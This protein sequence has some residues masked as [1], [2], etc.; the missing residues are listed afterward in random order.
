MQVASPPERKEE[1]ALS[2]ETELGSRLRALTGDNERWEPL[3]SKVWK[4]SLEV[5]ND[6]F[7]NI[8]CIV[9]MEVCVF[10]LSWQ[11]ISH[12]LPDVQDRTPARK[13]FQS[14]CTCA[15]RCLSSRIL[16]RHNTILHI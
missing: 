3:M 5:V 1:D 15:S 12:L 9:G 13:Y 14:L 10:L 7:K 8:E 4:G 2:S 16:A 11:S 6:E